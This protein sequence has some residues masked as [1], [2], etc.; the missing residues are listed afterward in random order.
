VNPLRSIG[1]P[2]EFAGPTV[3]EGANA[4]ADVL[5]AFPLPASSVSTKLLNFGVYSKDDGVGIKFALYA[6]D[7]SGPKGDPVAWTTKTVLTSHAAKLPPLSPFN[8]TKGTVYWIA[9]LLN[10]SVRIARNVHDG[11]VG[12]RVGG[13][14]YGEAFPSSPVGST[15]NNVD[16]ALFIEVQDLE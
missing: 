6:G 16:W 12:R 13:V 5:Y 10:N 4:F 15:L 7:A 3:E 14:L 2:T 9:I 8:L 1:W 11:A